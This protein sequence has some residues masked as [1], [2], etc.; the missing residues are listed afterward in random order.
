MTESVRSDAEQAQ[1]QKEPVETTY[2]T[3]QEPGVHAADTAVPVVTP[4]SRSS[5]LP[6]SFAQER[7]WFLDQLESESPAHQ[8]TISQA[9]RLLGSLDVDALER[10][11]NEIVRR[12][13]VL[14]TTFV[15]TKGQP[16]QVISSALTLTLPVVDLRE[17]PE[18]DREPE[19]QRL[20]IEEAE[21][22]FDLAQGPLLRVK[23]LCLSQEDHVLFLIMHRIVSDEWSVGLFLQ[24][25]AALYEAF[26]AD[27]P[28]TLPELPVQY[29]DWADWQRQYLQGETLE[30][31]L[32]YWKQQ[33]GGTLPVLQLPT[34]R[35]RPALRTEP[36][37]RCS[38]VLSQSLTEAL[39]ALSDQAGVSLFVTLLAAFK[40]LLYRHT[41][42][43]DVIVGS[44]IS[45]R[46]QPESQ[47]LIGLLA[48]RLVLRTDLSSSSS[49][50]GLLGRIGEVAVGA[51]SHQGMP[52]EKLVEEL[53]PE[54]DLSR[55]PLYQV[56]F[57]VLDAADGL[58][59]LPGLAVKPFSV[60]VTQS[61]ADVTLQ[62]QEQDDG[63]QLELV[64]RADL[65]D[66]GRMVEMLEQL[67][68]LLVQIAEDP[69]MPIQS[70][71]LVTAKSRQLL[72]DP[73]AA[74]PEP[75][76]EPITAVF[77]SWLK[78]PTERVAIQEGDRTWTYS[79]LGKGA[80]VLAR[81]LV[82]HGVEP[83]DVVAVSGARSFGLIAS[84]AGV[85]LSG[86]VLLNLDRH[87]PR[88]RQE[89]ML[90]EA[91]AKCLLYIG[92][93]RATDDWMSESL[94]VVR[95]D[96]DTAQ[97]ID[98]D[99]P[100]PPEGILLPEVAPEDAAYLFFTSGSTGVPKGVLGCHKGLA[101]FVNWQR[102]TFDIGPSDRSAQ[103][104][105]LSFDVVLRDIFT[106]LT[107][108]ATLCLPADDA[109]LDPARLLPW[110]ERERITMLHTV[111]SLAQSWLS[112]APPGVSLRDLRLV[113]FAGEPLTETLVHRWRETWPESAGIVNLYG[114]TETTLAKC[115]FRVPATPLPGVQP[116]GSP[117][118]ETQA[119][120]LAENDQ[121][122][123]I[124]EPGQIVLRTPFRSLGYIN[125][126]EENRRRFVQ[127]PFRN[128]K[129]D[130]VYYTGDRGR[131]RPDGTLD[132]LGRV[133]HQVKIRGVRI[134]L[135]ELETVLGQHPDVWESV[136][137]VREET[138][139]DKRLVAYV[140]PKPDH[141]LTTHGLHS[142][143][144]QK[145]PDAMVPSAFVILDTL[146]LTPNGKVDRRALPEPDWQRPILEQ[147]YVA[148]R[149]PFE[150][151]LAGIWA[152]ILG[153]EQVGIRD[154][155]FVL[156]GHS[157]LAAQ[158]MSRLRDTLQI[159]L[160]LR[161]L[162]DTPT[163]A[164]LAELAEGQTQIAMPAPAIE[165][166][167]RDRD[168]PLSPAQ[169][170]LW[171]IDQ[172]EPGN[173]AY[174]LSYAV[175]LSG[176]LD[177]GALER[178][179]NEIVRRHESLRTNLAVVNG[180]PVQIV[181][182]SL[183]LA[184]PITDLEGLPPAQQEAKIQQLANE[185]A[186][187]RFDLKRDP[188][189]RA[190]LLRQ[191]EQG[192]VLILTI[193]HTVS[194]G[195]SIGVFYRELSALY[196]AFSS[197]QSSPLPELRIQY[198]D[199]AIWQRQWLQEHALESQLSYWKQQLGS[200]PPVLELP[201]DRLRPAVQ[202]YRGAKKFVAVSADLHHALKAVSQQERCTLFMTLLA[203]F[204][205]LLYRYSGQDD[206]V[207]GS[208]IANRNRPE[209]EGLIGLFLNML[210][211]R[212]DLSGDPTFRELLARVREV[213][214]AA[215]SN[216]DVPFEKLVQAL[217]PPRD[218]SRSPLFQ[219]L[220]EV[221]P[222][223]ALELPGLSVS[224]L[225][226]DNGA[227]QFDLSLRLAEG[228]EGIV[229][230][231]EYNTDLF[232]AA[233]IDRL[234]A[235]LQT[236]L[237]SAA[238]D[239]DQH[240]SELPLLSEPEKHRILVEWNDTAADYAHHLCLHQLFE[241]Q[242]ER[243]PDA[244]AV[245]FEGDA[246]TYRA[247]NHRANQL[248]HHLQ[249]LGVGPDVLVGVY[250]ERSLEMVIAL[251]GILKAGGA[252]VPLDPEYPPER[253][254]FMLEDTEVPVLLTQE[255]LVGSLP[256]HGARVICLDSDWEIIAREGMDSPTSG[257]TAD[258]LAYVIYTSGS[259]GRPK[260][261]MN[262]HR[263]IS[264]RLLW[265]QDMYQL[266]E[267]D[268]VLQKT[269]FSFD[270]SVWEFFWPLLV[271]ARLVVAR[272]RGHMDSAYL[273]RTV[274]QQ[275]I[276]TLHFVP[277]M[278]RIFLEDP[279]VEQC[280]SLR[281]VICSGEALPYDLQERFFARLSAE[282]HNLYGP[283]EAA[284]DVSYWQCRRQSNLRTVPIG[285]PVANTQLYVL[286]RQMQPVPIGVAGE[287]H[288][289]GVQ[290]ARGYLNRPE[291]TASKF[292]PDP[293]SD[294][295]QARLYKTGDVVRFLPDGNIEFL[296]RLDFQV[297]VRGFRIELGEIE[298]VMS[299][300]PA[301]RETVVVAREEVP[302][303]KRL[304]AYVVPSRESAPCISELREYLQE[305]LPEYMVPAAFVLLEALPLT[306]S[307]KVDRRNLP[308]PEWERQSEKDYVPP[309]KELEKT[310]ADIWQQL[311]QLERVGIDDSF[312]ELGGH[313]LLIVQAH[314]RLSGLTDRE[315]SITD[316]FRYPTI[317]T[318][319]EYLSQDSGDDSQITTQESVD[320]AKTRREAMARRRRQRQS[321]RT[322]TTK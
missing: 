122:C 15:S 83:G 35:P 148:P 294:D 212:T 173:P 103:L 19:A 149:T 141:T 139:G 303:D 180:Q 310:I 218:P 18:T 268:R 120:I 307:G 133:D 37:S 213:T 280:R 165:P 309:Q 28:S 14:R 257:V 192:H 311:L 249:R 68:H 232:D 48:N 276:T 185:E 105:G 227:A 140:T 247:L 293:F 93:P 55:P 304:V 184:L 315:L 129:E 41:G 314:R 183:D 300:H 145:L 130:L 24:E 270:V 241:R 201:T 8:N 16:V 208:P 76:H 72:P 109:I 126:S 100:V 64:Y 161:S 135:G 302:G 136:A 119:L 132:I 89:V 40:T 284:V 92:T 84:M 142:Y 228:A 258:N 75:R 272:P 27:K 43:E 190:S 308:A 178:S 172:L 318:L 236:L 30:S 194:D 160:P 31:E 168:L 123:G 181:S 151:T 91:E 134:E 34:D 220:F 198:P 46:N 199:F 186:R 12:H 278:L 248:A 74:L 110:I 210:V 269:P 255:H 271:G 267:A 94:T 290:V 176:R 26:S 273:V 29:A 80:H 23:L 54:R 159:E 197:G 317:R 281:R 45:G 301:V 156:G 112:D 292:V 1:Q 155:F 4:V 162:F 242:T 11:L 111:P 117:L 182:A 163:I 99:E 251:Y 320:R 195:W 125:A 157:L 102:E 65:F 250:M 238:L 2:L 221:S 225:E 71:S 261:V 167:S 266:T 189:I 214:L 69:E 319:S 179:L 56:G 113:F 131:Y 106:P 277:S 97:A 44:L 253:V 10:S 295:P 42:Q 243:T 265:M 196:Q 171:F 33:L 137:L 88:R 262:S 38:L 229:G 283:T 240:I 63:V 57:R 191:G 188:L 321:K 263:G 107:S 233:T 204:K 36:D 51:H 187:H 230:H 237:A 9:W 297:K 205:T 235:H 177:V 138:T 305:K 39:K 288:I 291:L 147:G 116:V 264:N 101:H 222:M 5:V 216:Q 234:A 287:L 275:G 279:E 215:Y 203:A 152:Q 200:N 219:V 50:R 146:P 20:A 86:G 316:M 211:F 13:E 144:K 98:L 128:D 49:F 274:V 254:A 312:F 108:G 245:S 32:G 202:T 256:E 58:P 61:R 239:P 87:L 299:Q 154:D 96:P 282:L 53:Q 47:G 25:M 296:G 193:H 62:V 3:A 226:V 313:S 174:N 322:E 70:Y 231:F 306:P 143:L 78:R 217:Q 289:G 6:L 286:D 260:G 85:F 127:N 259:T 22:A 118:P 164:G 209:L 82:V 52:F 17:L 73:R 7:L 60:P 66:Q 223:E 158:V 150:E 67:K 175:R 207:V 224:T 285:R 153:I 104:T 124:G 114:P 81:A 298:A 166:Y 90:E 121:L 170:P 115:Y 59:A 21:R 77:A 206:I 246:L 95:V 252:Y 244:V 169:E 79:E